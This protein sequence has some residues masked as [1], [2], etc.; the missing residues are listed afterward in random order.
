MEILDIHFEEGS[1]PVLRVAGELD[2]ATADQLRGAL[3]DA[4]ATD[5]K[6]VLDMGGVTFVDA[7]GIRVILEAADAM[8]GRGPL[9]ITNAALFERLL[10]I[11]GLSEMPSIVIGDA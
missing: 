8:N 4:L 6:C 7:S 1:P 10:K 11:V 3:R 2:M 5:F 9:T